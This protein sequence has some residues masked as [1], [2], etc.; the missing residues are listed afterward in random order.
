MA[1]KTDATSEWA[2]PGPGTWERDQS[3]FNPTVSRLMLDIMED[4]APRGVREGFDRIG[5]PLDTM[6][7]RFVHGQMYRRLVP[8]IGA[9]GKG[10]SKPP[11]AWVMKAAFAAVP[12]LRKRVKLATRTLTNKNW[13]A[14]ADRW[15]AEWKPELV[16]ANRRLAGVDVQDLDDADLGEHIDELCEHLTDATVLHFRLHISDLGP[17]GMLLGRARE[18]GVDDGGVMAV[19]AGASP[20]TSAPRDALRPL[21]QALVARGGV[22]NSFEEI[23]IMGEME[24][25]L[26]DDYLIEFGSRLTTGYDL[27][28]ATLAEMP[29]VILAQLGDASLLKECTAASNAIDRGNAALAAV[30]DRIPVSDLEEFDDLVADARRFYGLRD[31]NGPLTVQWPSGILRMA[32]LEASRRFIAAGRL[33]NACHVFDL[34]ATELVGSLRGEPGPKREAVATRYANRMALVELDSPVFLGPEPIEPDLDG[35]P[36][37]MRQMMQMSVNV[38]SLLEAAPERGKL[39][40]TGVGTQKYAGT[41]R[42]VADAGE[43]IERVEP[44]DVIVTRF[45]A[46]TF[47]AVL[48]TAGAV[49]TEHGGLLCHTAVIA[50]ELGIAAVVGVEGALE[51]PDGAQVEV[52]PISGKVTVLL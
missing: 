21:A 7:V 37:A 28:D 46:P 27:S 44:G 1:S 23:R 20:A 41:A 39:T 40:G 52:D 15:D 31:E 5:A 35:L 38:F 47:N 12:K 8:I 2:A 3:H 18:W 11:P 30:R 14:E 50:R 45:T 9:S 51:I 19:L 32:L 33:A 42:V 10:P 25:R 43:A 24:R 49:V 34:S 4:A 36:D 48:A 6:D 17:I 16:A 13:Q 26:L 29:D 22:P